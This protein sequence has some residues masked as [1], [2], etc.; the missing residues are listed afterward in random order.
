M[1]YEKIYYALIQK[2]RDIPLT[3]DKQD[4]SYVYCEWHHII[5]RCCNGSNEKSNLVLLTAREHYIAHLLLRKMHPEN[6]GLAYAIVMMHA[7]T[8]HLARNFRFNSRLF[9]LIKETSC[10]GYRKGKFI[11]VTNGIEDWYQLATEPIPEGC[12][13]GMSDQHK[14]NQSKGCIGRKGTTTG[15]IAIFNIVTKAKKHINPLDLVLDGWTTENPI[16]GT[17]K[18]F[19]KEEDEFIMTHYIKESVEFCNT[20]RRVICHRIGILQELYPDFVP[21][22]APN[23]WPGMH[24]KTPQECAN[25]SKA[26]KGK[27]KSAKQCQQIGNNSRGR[28][29]FTNG[30]VNIFIKSDV[31]PDGFW[32]GVTYGLKSKS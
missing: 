5:P 30:K 32:P 27:P 8:K 18:Q 2:R 15:K 25:I 4:P 11:R 6:Q 3:K 26:L 28:K 21:L 31:C 13:R 23:N 19:T 14:L 10:I 24:V 9:A 1:N 29:H 7:K 20:T 16:K 22:K 12:H 17:R